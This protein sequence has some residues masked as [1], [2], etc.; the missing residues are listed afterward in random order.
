[1][2]ESISS[3]NSTY[4]AVAERQPVG[5][6]ERHRLADPAEP[7]DHAVAAREGGDEALRCLAADGRGQQWQDD[8]VGLHAAGSRRDQP[9]AHDP[10]AE[11]VRVLLGQGDDRHPTHRVADEHDR[12]VGHRLVDDPHQVAAALLDGGVVLLGATGS[13]VGTLV[14]ED[15][16]HQPP[17]GGPLEVPRVEVEG[18]AVHEHHRQLRVAA[19]CSQ[20]GATDELRVQLVDL[21]VQ[22][23]AVIGHDGERV[24]AQ[25][26]ERCLVA[27][28]APGNDAATLGDAQRSPGRGDTDSAGRHPED[29]AGGAHRSPS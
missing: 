4:L 7:V 2:A 18:V 11:D 13:P 29:A 22:G 26:P 27:R 14:E 28:P 17:V 25:R 20:A 6:H 16:A 10:V 12:S 3:T 1:V 19:P 21:D 8:P 15:R 5:R 23:H 9:D 24:G